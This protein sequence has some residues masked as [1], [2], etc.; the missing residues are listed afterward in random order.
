MSIIDIDI[1]KKSYPVKTPTGRV[2]QRSC[3]D[4]EWV[5]DGEPRHA[6]FSTS[7]EAEQY[8][9]NRLGYFR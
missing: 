8:A 7:E 9:V 5:Q 6:L 4:V 1:K 2:V 3:W